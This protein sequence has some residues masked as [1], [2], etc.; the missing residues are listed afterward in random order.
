MK[1]KASARYMTYCNLEV[2]A[3]NENDAFDKAFRAPMSDCIN[4]RYEGFEVTDVELTDDNFTGDQRVF[5]LAF[6]S[7]VG[8]VPSDVL[9]QFVLLEDDKDFK[10]REYYTSLADARSLWELA[11]TYFQK[12]TNETI[13]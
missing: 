5:M 6:D 9:K 1:Y 12:E 10:H 11:R 8:D 4:H 7:C 3:D 2:E 13:S